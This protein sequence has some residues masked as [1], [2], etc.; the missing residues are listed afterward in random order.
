M[1]QLPLPKR[2]ALADVVAAVRRYHDGLAAAAA[3][4]L[5]TSEVDDRLE[6]LLIDIDA[7]LLKA[8]DLPPRLER[9]LLE[10]FRGHE[11]ERRVAGSFKGWFPEDFTAYVP[12]HEY[13]GPLLGENTGAW[14]LDIFTPAPEHEV[15]RLRL[16]VQ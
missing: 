3:H 10:A 16:Y 2:G 14:T 11:T 4:A 8:Y 7:Q 12:L 6:D 1:R 15:E 5:R 9:R 13:I